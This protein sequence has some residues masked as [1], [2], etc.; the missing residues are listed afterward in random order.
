MIHRCFDFV[1]YGFQGNTFCGDSSEPYFIPIDFLLKRMFRFFVNRDKCSILTFRD[2]KWHTLTFRDKKLHILMR[3][4][5]EK[6]L[7]WCKE[8]EN[9]GGEVEEGG[10]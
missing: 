6:G 8:S 1:I 5:K 9:A 3:E 4:R 10:N 7:W 2:K